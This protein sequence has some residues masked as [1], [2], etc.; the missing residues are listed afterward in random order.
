MAEHI[1]AKR[2][3]LAL[4]AAAATGILTWLGVSY[5]S[6]EAEAFDDRTYFTIALPIVAIVCAYLGFS[7]P[8]KPWRY[9]LVAIG[10]HGLAL[11]YL[12]SVGPELSMAPVGLAILGV[13][14]IP[15]CLAGMVGA[16]AYRQ[17]RPPSRE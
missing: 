7:V 12:S 17:S 10:M 4:A 13:I 8:V 14:S 6:L 1:S 11:L 15:M 9:G 5:T 2:Q 3:N 16:R